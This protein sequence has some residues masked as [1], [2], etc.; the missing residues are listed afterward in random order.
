MK[1]TIECLVQKSLLSR[2][3]MSIKKS[4]S[5]MLLEFHDDDFIWIEYPST[6]FFM[7][8]KRQYSI[9]FN[10]IKDEKS[11]ETKLHINFK[12]R[13]G[14]GGLSENDIV[15][16]SDCTYKII[17]IRVGP[18]EE[19]S[20][21]NIYK[22]KQ[23]AIIRIIIERVESQIEYNDDV[24]DEEHS[25]VKIGYLEEDNKEIDDNYIEILLELTSNLKE[26]LDSRLI[27]TIFNQINISTE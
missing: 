11:N 10:S 22:H 12:N 13:Y 17:I 27:G 19:Q 18:D 1:S 4:E 23:D 21:P 6:G 5:V 3:L 25:L 26:I 15:F 14:L 7:N 9:I 20:A 24:C 16:N 8:V 2:N